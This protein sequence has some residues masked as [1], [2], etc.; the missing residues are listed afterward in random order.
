MIALWEYQQHWHKSSQF[1]DRSQH[2]LTPLCFF[3]F[4]QSSWVTTNSQLGFVFQHLLFDRCYVNY[5]L[6]LK[7]FVHL[8]YEFI[9]PDVPL[10]V[11]N[12]FIA[13]NQE[14]L[15]YSFRPVCF[16]EEIFIFPFDCPISVS[17]QCIREAF[18]C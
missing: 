6:L 10:P 11:S 17:N 7:V 18:L 4:S 14:S 3:S 9:P 1:C 15:V 8:E 5:I 13:F 16:L 2:S 12:T